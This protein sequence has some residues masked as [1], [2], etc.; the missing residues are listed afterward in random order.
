MRGAL[1][2]LT[3]NRVI[4][5]SFLTIYTLL[6]ESTRFHSH[7]LGILTTT[8][9]AFS[10]GDSPVGRGEGGGEGRGGWIS[11]RVTGAPL[12]PCPYMVTAEL[13][14]ARP[15]PKSTSLSPV[16]KR[17]EETRVKD[18]FLWLPCVVSAE[19][20]KQLS[21][22]S[23][24]HFLFLTDTHTQTHT[25]PHL[26]HNC[27]EWTGRTDLHFNAKRRVFVHFSSYFEIW[28]M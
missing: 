25:F 3:Q 22:P 26:H 10:P 6:H 5:R 19:R 18:V 9:P 2:F 8:S 27:A 11:D 1:S 24:A 7:D 28:N 13:E 4:A 12:L 17:D 16:L 15:R 14:A 21:E 23:R 20:S